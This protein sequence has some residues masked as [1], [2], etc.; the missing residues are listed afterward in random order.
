MKVSSKPGF[1]QIANLC[2]HPEIK[3]RHA[4]HAITREIIIYMRVVRKR[5]LFGLE[6]SLATRYQ[7]SRRFAV[8]QTH[9][10]RTCTICLS[11]IGAPV[12]GHLMTKGLSSSRKYPRGIDRGEGRKGGG[13]RGD[14]IRL[15]AWIGVFLGISFYCIVYMRAIKEEEG[16]DVPRDSDDGRSLEFQHTGNHTLKC[17]VCLPVAVAQFFICN[18]DKFK[19]SRLSLEI[20]N[21][22]EIPPTPMTQP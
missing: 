7:I 3:S 21:S 17:V 15:Q 14:R 6:R 11:R 5:M 10:Q 4:F 18:D 2:K 13:E 1:R 19:Q 8:K 22:P 16:N 20:S 9:C 12:M